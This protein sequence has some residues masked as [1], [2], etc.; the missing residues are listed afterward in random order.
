MRSQEVDQAI[1]QCLESIASEL[2]QLSLWQETPP[3]PEAMASQ[4]PFCVDTLTFQQWLQFI[5][6]PRM[7]AL[8]SAGQPLPHSADIAPMAEESF[9]HQQIPAVTLVG[10]LRELDQ[11]ITENP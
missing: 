9:K 10:H 11:L 3:S 1:H 4:Q 7:Q 5:L 8:L 2:K 6:V